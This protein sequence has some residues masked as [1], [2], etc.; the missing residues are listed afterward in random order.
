MA[1]GTFPTTADAV[2]LQ[3][4]ADLMLQYGQLKKRFSVKSITGT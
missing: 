1:T 3:R 2:Q 4:V